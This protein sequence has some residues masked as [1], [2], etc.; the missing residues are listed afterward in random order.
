MRFT[1]RILVI[2]FTLFYSTQS[3]SQVAYT[4][5]DTVP[6]QFIPFAYGSNMGYYPGWEDTEVSDI[7]IGNPVAGIPGVGVNSLR[8]SLPEHFLEQWGY[9]VRDEEFDHYHNIGAR[10]NT[11]FIGYPS[12][13]HTDPTEYCPG[14]KSKVFKNLYTP[15]WDGGANGTPVNDE[16]YYAL[17]VYKML[18]IYGDHGQYWEISN[19]PDFDYTG[20]AWRP[21]GMD[22]SWWDNNPPP[23]Q[24][25]L[26]A[27]VFSYVRMLRISYEVIKTFYP[28][29][30]IAIGGLGYPSFL[31]AVCR[32]TDNPD[33]GQVTDEYPLKG[34]AYFDCMS[35]HTYP[36]IDGS[37]RDWNNDNQAFDYFRHS[38]AAVEGIITLKKEFETVLNNYGYGQNYPQKTFII[39]ESNIPRV[40]FDEFIGSEEAQ[41]NFIIK[42]LVEVQREDIKQFCVFNLGETKS[43]TEANSEF[44]LMGL[45][46][47]LNATEYGQEVPNE[48]GI[49]YKTTSTML[50]GKVYDPV[51]TNEMLPNA[52]VKAAAFK[53]DQG[54]Y[55][56]VLWAKTGT[57]MS[58]IAT[59]SYAF[60]PFFSADTLIVKNWDFSKTGTKTIIQGPQIQLSGEPVFI[61]TRTSSI[62]VDPPG[63]NTDDF[64]F[65][66][67]PNPYI[68]SMEII[69]N[70]KE[71]NK[72]SLTVFDMEGH[73]LISFH[74][75]ENLE[76]GAYKFN[77]ENEIPPGAY[78]CQLEVGRENYHCKFVRVQE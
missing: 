47:N 37:L 28:D 3:W 48:A 78:V 77:V 52:G 66:C 42:S 44:Q 35:F 65:S 15:I 51:R 53:D 63:T 27:P 9:E 46:Y 60:P 20:H 62:I 34:G 32:N 75:R 38:D 50:A 55:T 5:N 45:Y 25:A 22:G 17:Y 18:M 41:R 2:V 11:I 69:L 43:E 31:D 61:D 26:K 14:E 64:Y 57:D 6:A 70:L 13:D 76:A 36:H 10:N 74:Y 67:F 24:N 40:A 56:Y 58:E 21:A 16:N 73:E 23:C 49:G 19:E 30:Y 68:N 71:D 1:K 33:N 8:P 29:S 54:A 59:Q 39:T 7:A 12:D 72:I 4:A